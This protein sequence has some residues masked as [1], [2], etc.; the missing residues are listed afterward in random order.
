PVAF[1]ALALGLFRLGL[2]LDTFW[3]RYGLDRVFDDHSRI[4]R[5]YIV[6]RIARCLIRIGRLICYKC[7]VGRR[8]RTRLECDAGLTAGKFGLLELFEFLAFVP[9]DQGLDIRWD[10]RRLL[11]M[12]DRLAFHENTHE[13]VKVRQSAVAAGHI[14]A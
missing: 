11:E 14:T 7:R 13:S 12:F 10:R 3:R 9:G 8:L 4:R 2:L 6:R 5:P 1:F